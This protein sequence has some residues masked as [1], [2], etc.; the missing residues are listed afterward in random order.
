MKPFEKAIVD[1]VVQSLPDEAQ[2]LSLSQL[3]VLQFVERSNPRIIGL[4][5][6]DWPERLKI[7]ERPFD[8]GLFK[9]RIEVDGKRETA[10]VL[11]YNGF[12]SAIETK[13][14]RKFYRG[15][16]VCVAKVE[17]GNPKLSKALAIDRQEH[18]K[19]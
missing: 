11:Y 14:H 19:E 6:K 9:V 15:K 10:N 1:A 18:G 16:T 7:T 8:D 13:N 2:K 12:I 5:L 17:A 4:H 3:S